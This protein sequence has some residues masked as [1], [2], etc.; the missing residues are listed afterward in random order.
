M[1]VGKMVIQAQMPVW[2]VQAEAVNALAM[3]LF[4]AHLRPS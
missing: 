1:K 2:L 4:T 3:M